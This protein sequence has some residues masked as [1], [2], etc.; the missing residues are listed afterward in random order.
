MAPVGLNT[1]DTSLIVDG[2]KA[3]TLALA[4]SAMVSA[5]GAM[6]SAVEAEDACYRG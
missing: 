3:A 4:S 2:K 6:A 1:A 5:A